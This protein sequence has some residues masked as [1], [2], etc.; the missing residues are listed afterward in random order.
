MDAQRPLFADAKITPPRAAP[1]HAKKP[2]KSS[3]GN[4]RTRLPSGLPTHVHGWLI[5][6][7][8][9]HAHICYTVR[10]FARP[11]TAGG[12]SLEGE[13]YSARAARGDRTLIHDACLLGRDELDAIVGEVQAAMDAAK[14]TVA[15]PGTRAKVDEMERRAARGESIFIDA[16]AKIPRDG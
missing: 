1:S 10:L 14:P 8:R 16:D 9:V 7:T 15:L 6:M 3:E 11:E 2:A 4:R 5:R 13:T 12:Q